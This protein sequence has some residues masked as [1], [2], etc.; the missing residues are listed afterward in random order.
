MLK[1]ALLAG[2]CL[3][4]AA[5]ADADTVPVLNGFKECSL[6]RVSDAERLRYSMRITAEG[7]VADAKIVQSSG[8]AHYDEAVLACISSWTYKP[9]THNGQP[10]EYVAANRTFVMVWENDEKAHQPIGRLKYDIDHRCHKLYPVKAY[11]LKPGHNIALVNVTRLPSGEVQTEVTQSAGTKADKQAVTCIKALVA[12]PDH[13][14]LPS[15]FSHTF[16][17]RWEQRN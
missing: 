11:D 1:Y 8:D 9:A 17:V 3:M 10:V 15:T 7:K 6:P 12:D 2:V 4:G 16:E 5:S 14:D 13:A